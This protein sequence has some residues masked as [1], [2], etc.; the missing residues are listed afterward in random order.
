M[1]FV[2]VSN[3]LVKLYSFKKKSK[4]K[5]NWMRLL[6]LFWPMS[7]WIISTVLQPSL[8]KNKVV[9]NMSC[10][11]SKNLHIMF[12]SF[13]FLIIPCIGMGDSYHHATQIHIRPSSCKN[14]YTNCILMGH[15][16]SRR[17]NKLYEDGMKTMEILMPTK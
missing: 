13:S 3:I 9:Y 11:N 10:K 16:S 17:H 14:V 5:V 7:C 1:K 4:R 2:E 15:L 12:F 6:M 8:Y